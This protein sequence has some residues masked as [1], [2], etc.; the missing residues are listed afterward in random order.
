MTEA[1]RNMMLETK[2]VSRKCED[3]NS[4]SQLT[5]RDKKKAYLIKSE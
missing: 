5:H 3:E 1:E 4:D 2:K